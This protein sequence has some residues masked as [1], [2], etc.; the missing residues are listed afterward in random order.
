MADEETLDLAPGEVQDVDPLEKALVKIN[1]TR[2]VLDKL[3]KEAEAFPAIKTKE[4]YE[5][6]RRHRLD[7]V[8]LRTT[9]E[10]V[11]KAMREDAN[12]FAARVIAKEKEIKGDI[13]ASEAIDQAKEDAYL[14][15]LK[16]EQDEKD[17]LEQ[18]RVDAML[19]QLAAYEWQGNKFEVAQDTP[20]QFAERL[21]K[22]QESFRLIEAGRKAE[23]E[24]LAREE[25]ER[26]ARE[27]AIKAEEERQAKV[28]TEQEAAAAKLR[29][30][31]E[32]FAKQQREAKEAADRA[33]RERLAKIAEDER[34]AREAAEAET[35]RLKTE[36]DA[37]K[38]AEDDAKAAEAEKA[39]LAELAPD[40][41]KIVD[42]TRKSWEFVS[43][44]PTIHDPDMG[45]KVDEA[46][47]SIAAIL[48]KLRLSVTVSILQ[49]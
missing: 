28:R 32:A 1:V 40:V 45:A 3:R 37:R 27:S 22:A 10:K 36:A 14:A 5:K 2:A 18:V 4:D 21:A 17:R 46:A 7:M 20:A 33:E 38:K 35:L 9:T 15:I 39:R 19:Q 25:Q 29:A 48:D 26:L 43:H 31:Q 11:M 42:W 8:P 30:E 44:V 16:A 12:A 6:V 13:A 24:R 34:K 23:A 41:D 49:K 47:K